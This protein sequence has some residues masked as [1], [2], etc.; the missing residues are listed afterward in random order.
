QIDISGIKVTITACVKG[1]GMICPNMATMLCFILTDAAIE[2]KALKSALKE[3]VDSSFNC[4]TIDG[5]MST[6]DTVLAL[7]NGVAGNRTLTS[8]SIDF[9]KFKKALN[10]ICLDLAE[11]IV[12]DGEGATKVIEIEVKGAKTVSD[13]KKAA[14]TVA[15]SPLV[16]TALYGND[17]NWGRIMAAIGYSGISFNVHKVDIFLDNLQIVKNSTT[18]AKDKTANRLLKKKNIK[19][20]INLHSGH[21]SSRVLTCDLTEEYIKINAEYKT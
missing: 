19:I 14:K 5:D 21:N 11:M 18:T 9:K 2:Q 8:T 3:T 7:A 13:A 17:A 10:A 20:L 16:K 6:N 12:S 1:A 4:I 15:N